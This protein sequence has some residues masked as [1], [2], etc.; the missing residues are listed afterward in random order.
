MRKIIH[1]WNFLFLSNAGTALKRLDFLPV[2]IES[3]I[4]TNVQK[5]EKTLRSPIFVI[6]LPHHRWTKEVLSRSAIVFIKCL[7]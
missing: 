6:F 3:V 2:S 4:N 7:E 5:Q 1:A